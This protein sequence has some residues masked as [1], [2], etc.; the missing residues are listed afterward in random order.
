MKRPRHHFRAF[1]ATGYLLLVVSS[2]AAAFFLKFDFFISPDTYA[3]LVDALLFV[4][5]AKLPVFYFA[6]LHRSLRAFAD[7][8]DLFRLLASNVVASAIFAAVTLYSNGEIFPRSIFVIDFLICFISMVLVR[9]SATMRNE[10]WVWDRP[11]KK[12][13]AILIYGAGA[14]GS[15]LLREIRSHR[16]LGY[17][18]VGF[19][20]D[21]PS[22]RGALIM[23]VPVLGGGRE[24]A[25]LVSRLN[26]R[27]A[28]VEEIIIAMPSAT[29]REKREALAN[30]QAARI[31][32][33]TIP[34]V[35]D[36][37]N[38]KVLAEQIR[39]LS[40]TDLLGRPPVQLEEGPIRSHLAGRCVLVTGVAGSIGSELCRQ[41][42]RFNP[43][44]LIALD[45][46]ESELF[47][48]ECELRERHPDLD[49]TA[50]LGDIRD[51]DRLGELFGRYPID[52][53]FHAA[54]YK[55]VPMM[56]SHVLEAVS[57]N[58]LGT[59]NLVNVV[60]QHRVPSFLMISSDKAVNPTSV[61]GATK[62]V[63]EL[64]V[65]A[66]P[67]AKSRD[68][69]CV[70]VR[71]GN[72]LGSNGSVVPIFQS[73][74]A[75]GGPVKVTHPQIQRYF[76]TVSEAVSLVL[77]ASTM[78]TGSEIF[79]LDMGEPIRI[80]DL[81]VNMIRLAGLVPYQDIDIRFTGLRPGEKL[82]EETNT[83]AEHM[84]PTYHDK[85]MIFRHRPPDWSTIWEW[86]SHL[87][88]LFRERS[89]HAIIEH[90]KMLVP[91]YSPG[92]QWTEMEQPAAYG[93]RLS[94]NG[95]D[96]GTLVT[97]ETLSS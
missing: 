82:F 1:G 95:M 65:S 8:P 93:A 37:L 39:D 20:D 25:R 56:E 26:R 41:V 4:M 49:L 68:T 17:K 85:I 21:D 76:M 10:A 63:C 77:Q 67:P 73:Q 32:C 59:C 33:K 79:V 58:I 40:V 7:V 87:Q 96:P 69:N 84:L 90:I 29:G 64:I 80:V 12:G 24:A 52:A 71:F 6:G 46:A 78:G 61:M 31:P 60:R 34:G 50:A 47:R 97:A 55:H 83:A 53:V 54:A 44:R 62:R 88:T 51:P 94:A 9:F 91:E 27:R 35:A 57:N 42:A 13:K 28:K 5:L 16:S 48:I 86:L 22:K 75:A 23:G 70:S 45:Q 92:E 43:G 15:T 38:G 19:L 74:I 11:P 2:L 36:F 30:C 3:V 72:V 14:S 89:E 18:V 81:A 66:T